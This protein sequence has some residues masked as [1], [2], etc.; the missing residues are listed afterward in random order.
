MDWIQL[1]VSCEGQFLVKYGQCWTFFMDIRQEDMVKCI[2]FLRWVAMGNSGISNFS[3]FQYFP[4]LGFLMTFEVPSGP[5]IKCAD[6]VDFYYNNEMILHLLNYICYT[7]NNQTG[8]HHIK[9]KNTLLSQSETD[10]VMNRKAVI[11]PPF[12]LLHLYWSQGRRCICE[13]SGDRCLRPEASH[14]IKIL[15]PFYSFTFLYSH[16]LREDRVRNSTETPI[17]G[18]STDKK[19]CRR[20]TPQ[21]ID[22]SSS[23]YHEL[24]HGAMKTFSPC[25]R[26]LKAGRITHCRSA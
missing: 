22:W 2:Y 19:H 26:S 12:F 20:C 9:T 10:P 15:Q 5:H 6:C 14:L 16:I 8:M 17:K 3:I 4:W 23:L 18:T 24:I 7:I 13:V 11:P 25:D 21:V 1:H